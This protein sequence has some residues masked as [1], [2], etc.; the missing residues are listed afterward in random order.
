MLASTHAAHREALN[1]LEQ[2]ACEKETE[3]HGIL[4]D[5][6]AEKS[7]LK[8]EM[9]K[10][11]TKRDEWFNLYVNIHLLKTFSDIA[12]VWGIKLSLVWKLLDMHL[13]VNVL[14]MG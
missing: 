7:R 13:L 4:L 8:E 5:Q 9:T 14:C 11:Q 10:L 1:K 6:E 12:I 3:I 2:V